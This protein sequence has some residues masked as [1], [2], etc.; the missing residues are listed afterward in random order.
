MFVDVQE[1]PTYEL[2]TTEVEKRFDA[3]YNAYFSGKLT[4][5]QSDG[6]PGPAVIFIAN[7]DKVSGFLDS[8]R[9]AFLGQLA[10]RLIAGCLAPSKGRTSNL[11]RAGD[12]FV[13]GMPVGLFAVC[14][15]RH[16][17]SRFFQTAAWLLT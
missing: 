16:P 11:R 1:L 8:M 5:S 9:A 14:K 4:Q 12:L 13:T 3:I 6:N 17:Q 15:R 10:F 2:N 7:F